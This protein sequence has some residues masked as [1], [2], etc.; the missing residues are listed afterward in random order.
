M[1]IRQ[2]G[3][4]W[5]ILGKSYIWKGPYIK[6]PNTKNKVVNSEIRKQNLNNLGKID[7]R[8]FLA[9]STLRVLKTVGEVTTIKEVIAPNINAFINIAISVYI[10]YK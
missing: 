10:S 6:F 1:I 3:T 4:L 9:F 5:S 7:L 8:K 2:L